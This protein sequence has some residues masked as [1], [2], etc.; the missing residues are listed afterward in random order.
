MARSRKVRNARASARRLATGS[1]AAATPGA[2]HWQK[3]LL[4]AA[5]C[6][7]DLANIAHWS[8]IVNR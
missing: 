6:H 3:K 4:L 2:R 1:P 5:W 8:I 7:L